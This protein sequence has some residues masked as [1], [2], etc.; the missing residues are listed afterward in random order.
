MLQA[1]RQAV[2]M[3]TSLWR[4]LLSPRT[5]WRAWRLTR[6]GD[7]NL[8][9]DAAWRRARIDLHPDEMPYMLQGHLPAQTTIEEARHPG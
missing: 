8:T 3:S 7:G 4:C 2:R 6:A 1:L 9:F 5:S